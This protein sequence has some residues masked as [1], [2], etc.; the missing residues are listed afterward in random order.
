MCVFVF[1]V[2]GWLSRAV[3]RLQLFDAKYKSPP[4]GCEPGP[5][6]QRPILPSAV[7]HTQTEVQRAE[8]K[9]LDHTNEFY[10]LMADRRTR[11]TVAANLP[12][13]LLPP[14]ALATFNPCRAVRGKTCI[15]VEKKKKRR[16]D[17]LRPSGK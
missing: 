6:L 11:R 4:N 16:P 14:P 1:I 15:M 8:R 10:F 2:S 3:I 17:L 5:H 9:H 7:Q 12:P 13:P